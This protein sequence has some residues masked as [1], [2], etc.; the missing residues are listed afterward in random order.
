[1][2][3]VYANEINKMQDL[4]SAQENSYSETFR[5]V[6]YMETIFTRKSRES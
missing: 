1:M 6:S 4:I 3:H 2:Y 5:N